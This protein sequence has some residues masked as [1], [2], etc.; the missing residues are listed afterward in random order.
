MPFITLL[1]AAVKVKRVLF[2]MLSYQ[3][4]VHLCINLFRVPVS[5][6][7][8]LWLVGKFKD[9]AEC[10]N[11]VA[12]RTAE[13]KTPDKHEGNM[14]GMQRTNVYTARMTSYVT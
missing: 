8:F 4:F 12:K 14:R 6:F 11:N 10:L 1:S 13:G 7:C 5:P 9:K 2:M 3:H